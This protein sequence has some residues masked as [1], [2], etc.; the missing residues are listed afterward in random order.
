MAQRG[1]DQHDDEPRLEGSSAE[2]R[3]LDDRVEVS[4]RL[5]NPSARPLHYV[6]DVRAMRVDPA[7]GN[8]TVRLSEEGLEIP[9]G[10][11]FVQPRVRVIDPAS[12]AELTVALPKTILKL[13]SAPAPPGESTFEELPISGAPS[14]AIDIGWSDS[15]YYADRRPDS[16]DKNPVAAWEKTQLRVETRQL[17]KRS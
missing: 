15:P 14:I 1:R 6:S 13:G 7:T 8:V 12:E 9:P 3:E 10:G 2:V 11:F 5:R 4:I 16:S 17:E